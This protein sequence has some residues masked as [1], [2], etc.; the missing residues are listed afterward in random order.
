M[1]SIDRMQKHVQ[2]EVKVE[3]KVK[4]CGDCVSLVN[5]TDGECECIVEE[6]HI[7]TIKEEYKKLKHKK[8]EY[9]AFLKSIG[10]VIDDE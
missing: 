10:I 9:G 1:S 7:D 3:K 5:I 4:I 8:K 2:G 6:F